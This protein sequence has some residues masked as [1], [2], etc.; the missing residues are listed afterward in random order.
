MFDLVVMTTFVNLLAL[1]SSLWLGFYIVT[2]SAHSDLSRLAAVTLW[3]LSAFFLYNS[4]AIHLPHSGVLAWLRQTII[5]VLPVWFHVTLFLHP[6]VRWAP[7]IL[8][9]LALTYGVAILLFVVGVF[10]TGLVSDASSLPAVFTSGR[11]PGPLFVFFF[12]YFVLIFALIML[13]LRNVWENA[14]NPILRKQFSSLF[15]ATILAGLGGVYTCL[16][17][18]LRL[19]WPT[20]P[21]DLALAVGVLMLGYAVARYSALLEGWRIERD[22]FYTLMAVGSLTTFSL[23]SLTLSWENMLSPNLASSRT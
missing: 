20:L 8:V 6:P 15:L 1:A 10:G 17:I 4:L 12:L 13:N 2:R 7:G 5:L 14:A 9:G 23:S 18:E 3:L 22:F 16:G 21:G 19:D 11:A